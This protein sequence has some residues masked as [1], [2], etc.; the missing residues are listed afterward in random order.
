MAS[1]KRARYIDDVKRDIQQMFSPSVIKQANRQIEMAAASPGLLE[2]ALLDR[3]I[4]LIVDRGRALRSDRVRH[5]ADR[6]HAAAAAHARRDDHLDPGARQASPRGAR[7]RSR[8][9]ADAEAAAA[10]DPVLAALERRHERLGAVAQHR[11]WTGRAPRSRCV[12]HSRA[13]RDRGDGARGGAARRYRRRRRRADRQ[14]RAAGRSGRR[15]LPVA[16]GAG[17]D[18]SRGDRSALQAAAARASSASCRATST[19]L[20]PLTLVS[21]QLSLRPSAKI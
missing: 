7:D 11:S 1:A 16:Q 18:L 2:V 13:A 9:R 10:A 21:D 6:P 12:T 17:A 5:G 20:T 15:V 8:R 14:P 19:A 4:D 3:M